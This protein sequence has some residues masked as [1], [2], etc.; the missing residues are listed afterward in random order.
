MVVIFYGSFSI[1][2][3]VQHSNGI[4]TDQMGRGKKPKRTS[5][6][7]LLLKTFTFLMVVVQISSIIIND[8][9]FLLIQHSTVRCIGVG[10]S[11]C[12][13]SVLIIAMAT[14]RGSWRAGIDA[15]Q[16][17]VLISDGIYKLSRN[18]AFL[19]FDLFYIGFT[20]SFSNL[21]QIAWLFFCICCLHLQIMEEEKFLPTIFG[22]KYLKYKDTTA[23]Y[24]VVF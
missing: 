13:L 12:G 7:E 17:T 18:P 9:W 1:K 4:I 21:L 5:T 15:S 3:L 19:G 22:E 11:F 20:L 2:L 10:I 24:F 23:R 6:I 14:M 8:D 16:K